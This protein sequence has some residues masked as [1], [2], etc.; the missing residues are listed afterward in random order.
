MG[1]SS[2]DDSGLCDRTDVALNC[3]ECGL[4]CKSG[5][6]CVVDRCVPA[7]V[8]ENGQLDCGRACVDVSTNG[9]H[10]GGCG[11][12]CEPGTACAS[13]ACVPLPSKI[14]HVVLISQENHTFD[15]YFGNYC[16]ALA[17]SN[18][19]C[20]EGPNCCE[21]APATEPHGASPELLD[22]LNNAARDRNHAMAC[23]RDQINGG[24]MDRFVTGSTYV[25]TPILEQPCSSPHN[26]AVADAKSVATYGALADKGALADRY[27]QPVVGG[28]ASNDMYFAIARFQFKDNDSYPDSINSG[29]AMPLPVKRVSWKGRKTIGDVL[30]EHGSS[31]ASYVQGYGAAVD[32]WN[33]NGKCPI[34]PA[35][36]PTKTFPFNLA[37]KY[38]AGDVPFQY[39]AQFTDDPKRMKD[40]DAFAKALAEGT[41]PEFAYVKAVAVNNEH[42]GVASI[43]R[44]MTFVAETLALIEQSAYASDTLVLITM[45]EG[46]GFYDHVPPPPPVPTSYD[47]DDK[48]MPVPYGTRVPMI[49]LGPFARKGGVSHVVLE[50]SS[51]V[52]FL[53]LNFGGPEAVGALGN[54]DAY[55]NHIGSLLDPKTTGIVVPEGP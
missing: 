28:S 19:T 20:N 11:V 37:C 53:E 23:E 36:C 35:D 50:H 17:G 8:C 47:S 2:R 6:S 13:G 39:Y 1:C 32:A 46:G 45:D 24:L 5:E 30:I 16:K 27:F 29:C 3:G 31:F 9:E 26:W 54:R 34:A 38:D 22:D 55:V 41:L 10:C 18:P 52:K 43:S 44:G 49:A 12:L 51:I 48:N 7:L 4:A 25:H 33:T 42:P 14:E 21:A 15:S 40:Y